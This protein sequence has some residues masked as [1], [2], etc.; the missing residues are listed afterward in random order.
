MSGER[1]GKKDELVSILLVASEMSSAKIRCPTS[2]SIAEHFL[3]IQVTRNCVRTSL[4]Q[5]QKGSSFPVSSM[6][7]SKGEAKR[8]GAISVIT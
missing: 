5:R 1:P 8:E 4:T 3:S 6:V 7:S 2:V